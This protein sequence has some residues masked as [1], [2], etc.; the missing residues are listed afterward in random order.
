MTLVEPIGG[1]KPKFSIDSDGIRKS[2]AQSL[3]LSLSCPA[4]GSPI[5]TFRLVITYGVSHF[6]ANWRINTKV[7]SHNWDPLIFIFTIRELQPNMSSSGIAHS[8][9]SVS[10]DNVLHLSFV[11]P[12]GGSKPKFSLKTDIMGYSHSQS[13]SFSLTCPAQGSPIPTFRLVHKPLQ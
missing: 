5:P 8:I 3:S 13:E 1:S 2:H 11:E 10:E 6:R 9:I 12:I 4:Q 7:C